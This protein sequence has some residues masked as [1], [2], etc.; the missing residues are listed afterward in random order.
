MS[1]LITTSR[2]CSA[3]TTLFLTAFVLA[4]PL[5]L[6]N[7]NL[8]SGENPPC[9]TAAKT[10]NAHC[11]PAPEKPFTVSPDTR[12]PEFG[13]ARSLGNGQIRSYMVEKK[14]GRPEEIGILMPGSSLTGLPNASAPPSDGTWDVLDAN[15]DVV[16]PCCGYETVLDLPESALEATP[17][18]HIVVN[19]NNHGHPPPAIY[20]KPHFDFHFYT[21]SNEERTSITAPSAEAMC[22]PTLPLSCEDLETALK[23]LPD[24][25]MPPDYFS[26]GAV[27]P[28]MGNHLLDST[29]P[30]LA[31]APFDQT[32]I[33]G[34]WDGRISFFE[35]MITMDYLQDLSDTQCYDL[36]MPHYFSEAGFYPTRYCARHFELY[37]VYQIALDRFEWFP[38]N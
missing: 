33:F 15:G 25:Q 6:A 23:P 9:N 20:D 35:P 14:N 19:W 2:Y 31:G 32:W 8:P 26:P 12:A 28:G 29:A 11:H 24:A 3:F 4:S 7:K 22:G 5:V 18:K 21:I 16:W 30:E 13:L 38:A 36:K 17:F 34:T 1:I 27:E 10:H 37:D